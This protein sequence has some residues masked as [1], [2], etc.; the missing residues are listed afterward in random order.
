MKKI[1]LV[2][3]FL[4]YNIFGNSQNVS[5]IFPPDGYGLSEQEMRPHYFDSESS[6]LFCSTKIYNDTQSRFE[7]HIVLHNT[8]DGT[9]QLIDSF[10]ATSN[11]DWINFKSFTRYNDFLFFDFGKKLFRYNFITQV[12]DTFLEVTNLSG[13]DIVGDYLFY[14]TPGNVTIMNLSSEQVVTTYNA[15]YLDAFHI[16]GNDIYFYE[17]DFGFSG[18]KVYQLVRYNTLTN[19]FNTLFSNSFSSNF[20]IVR[21]SSVVRLGDHLIYT[22]NTSGN[23]ASYVSIDITNNSINSDFTFNVTSQFQ[24]PAPFLIN[25]EVFIALDDETFVSN[26]S[27]QPTLTTLGRLTGSPLITSNS[28]FNGELYRVIDR[29]NVGAEIWKT[30]GQTVEL[31]KDIIPGSEGGMSTFSSGIIH[32]NKLY[33]ANEQDVIFESDGTNI[34][35]LPLYSADL[36]TYVTVPLIADNANNIYYYGESPTLG[37]GL[38]KLTTESLSVNEL[39]LDSVSV[40]FYPNPAST[41]IKFNAPIDYVTVYNL[42][43]KAVLSTSNTGQLNISELESNTLYLMTYEVG[44][45]YYHKKLIVKP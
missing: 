26:G 2:L 43:G 28:L 6:T 13:F 8:T 11:V 17:A 18:T 42:E 3:L 23:T 34:G 31:L 9:N 33:F 14:Y 38:F 41:I 44:S 19:S 40:S 16:N 35:T 21:K 39:E 15:A 45:R 1:T 20:S 7:N 4:L 30:N 5:K 29:D 10:F 32:N 25:N 27:T 22:I 24:I 12:F 36:F 37:N